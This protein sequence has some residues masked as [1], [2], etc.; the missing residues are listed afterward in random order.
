[1]SEQANK[2]L[3]WQKCYLVHKPGY[4]SNRGNKFKKSR[5]LTFPH[6]GALGSFFP[7]LLI[8]LHFFQWAPWFPPKSLAFPVLYQSHVFVDHD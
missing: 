3:H 4:I 5:F 2:N 6:F 8:S 1:M 7:S